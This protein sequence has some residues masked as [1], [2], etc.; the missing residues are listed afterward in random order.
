MDYHILEFLKN[1]KSLHHSDQAYLENKL[2][3][4]F[5]TEQ[6]VPIE[7]NSILPKLKEL[8]DSGSGDPDGLQHI[9]DMLANNKSLYHSD[10]MY[11]ESNQSPSISE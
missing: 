4:Q 7:E 1:N 11:L 9:Y 2:N 8:I 6:E 5:S 10:H 3:S